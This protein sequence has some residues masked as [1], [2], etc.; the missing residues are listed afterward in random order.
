L[1]DFPELTR[2]G[3]V[4]RT[5]GSSALFRRRVGDDSLVEAEDGG[6][7]LGLAR[8]VSE[9][10][11]PQG[12]DTVVLTSPAS[13]PELILSG[14]PRV[15]PL[16]LAT[17]DPARLLEQSIAADSASHVRLS[18][19]GRDIAN[20]EVLNVSAGVGTFDSTI[21]GSTW[22]FAAARPAVAPDYFPDVLLL[23]GVLIACFV[24]TTV[25]LW[26]TS[27][28]R[29]VQI[30]TLNTD[31]EGRLEQVRA[32]EG[33]FRSLLEATPDAMVIVNKDGRVEIINAQAERLFGYRR[34]QLIGEL[35]EVLM[36]PRFRGAH[37]AHRNG[38]FGAPRTR[39]MG[40]GMDLLGL[41]HDGTEFPIEIS[42]SPL[43]TGSE[44][45]VLSAIRDITDRKRLEQKAQ[46]TKEQLAEET[47]KA[48]ELAERT[49]RRERILTTTLS[50]LSDFASIYDRTGRFLFVNQPLL[51]LW[52]ITL[53]E[54]VG[55][56]RHDLG[57]SHDSVEQLQ[58]SVE[59]VFTSQNSRTVVSSYTSPAG[60]HG[61]YETILSP[62][63][64]TDG[65]VEF[66][67]GCARDITDRKRTEAE[68]RMARD[69]AEAANE[70]KSRFLA[71]M[72]HEIRTPMNAIL[73]MADL[74]WESSLDDVQRQYVDIFRGNGNT[75][76]ALIND[77]LDLS[78]I[79][80]G[81]FE[82]E[83]VPFSLDDVVRQALELIASSA[84]AKQ[85]AL[86]FDRESGTPSSL[87]G[88]PLRLRQVLVNL[89]GNAVKF[90]VRGEIRLAVSAL[91][92]GKLQKITFAISDTGPG[93]APEQLDR[94]FADFA[95]ADS[96]TTRRFGGT[97]LGLGIS[98]RLVDLMGGRLEVTSTVG[99]GSTFTFS[100]Q[101][102]VG[103]PDRVPREVI[104]LEGSRVLLI[105][106]DA[107]NRLVLREMLAAWGAD[108]HDFGEP[109]RA[110]TEL[111]RAASE[112][113]PY[114]LAI[115]DARMP[116][117]DGFEAARRI[118]ALARDLP[119]VMLA[120]D[121]ERGDEL[122][123]LEAGISGFAVK[124][125][126]R[127][128]LLRVISKAMG[129]TV[130]ASPAA[131]VNATHQ[132]AKRGLSILVAEDFA[133][134]RVLI[135]AYLRGS[136]HTL[137]FADD[138]RH[139]VDLFMNGRF[140]L[141]LMDIQMPVMDGL[142]ATRTIRA[143]ELHEARPP[144][145]IVAVTANAR[146]EDIAASRL[147]GCDE[148]LSKPLSKRALLDAIERLAGHATGDSGTE[149]RILIEVPEG[150]EDLA[151]GYLEA[152][153][154]DVA[155]AA[156]LLVGDD[157]GGVRRLAHNMAGSGSSYG[158]QLV[159][160]LGF[161][162]EQSARAGDKHGSEQCLDSLRDYLDR[163]HLVPTQ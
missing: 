107:I 5:T 147:A 56:S 161:S 27:S 131:V 19:D 50:F 119:V 6:V 47:R 143:F 145:P 29:F 87:I 151:P 16:F 70:A 138:G 59:E 163:V 53:E 141:V 136:T 152:R 130:G 109:E 44:T 86:T 104:N 128:G 150:L 49:S 82:L 102:E 37:P 101:F 68:L 134:N 72:S 117:M 135:D 75:L 30:A 99:Q 142:E 8:Q 48:Q 45:V 31:L 160:E 41:R 91:T 157:F 112:P 126:N 116:D 20:G 111:A 83:R 121:A 57:H 4:D 110:L 21:H 71:T 3:W 15:T 108:C 40:V 22:R 42:L 129:V 113:Q 58:R 114:S 10:L 144:T 35:V 122:R 69:A 34:D 36:P 28:E 80:A 159:T 43:Q 7:A 158:F 92:C 74:L 96:S 90:T 2:A 100:G 63:F 146:S 64:G 1:R 106:D 79:E 120:S 11:V 125:V 60:Y 12:R 33:R 67:V 93:I 38:Y 17:A 139:A 137:T 77:I 39:G 124:P 85:L 76:L 162:L 81:R 23:G 51:D 73:G 61:V 78:K 65:T 46:E 88:D 97:G 154:S 132:S 32:T 13:R 14:R 54:A 62:A 98:R 66:V 9:G 103:T 94:I 52:G 118:R 149:G 55:K 156:A 133:D 18:I 140:D 24:A 95:Q 89:L 25:Y 26:Q 84:R 148:H 127:A 153:R 105:D 115:V 155:Q 123:R